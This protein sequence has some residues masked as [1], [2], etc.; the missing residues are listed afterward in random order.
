MHEINVTNRPFLLKL[1]TVVTVKAKRSNFQASHVK[2][3]S[4]TTLKKVTIL[5]ISHNVLSQ[6]TPKFNAFF[7]LCKIQETKTL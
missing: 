4:V 1:P 7:V 3:I 6:R 2:V 5:P